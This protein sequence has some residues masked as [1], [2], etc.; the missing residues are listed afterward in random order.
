MMVVETGEHQWR[1]VMNKAFQH[2]PTMITRTHHRVMWTPSVDSYIQT[3][4]NI[5]STYS[6]II[7]IIIDGGICHRHI[8][9]IIITDKFPPWWELYW[10]S[11]NMIM[12]MVTRGSRIIII[13]MA[14]CTDDV[15]MMVL[16]MDCENVFTPVSHFWCSVFAICALS[17]APQNDTF[18][19]ATYNHHQTI[20]KKTRLMFLK[21]KPDAVV[22]CR[23]GSTGD[24]R[25]TKGAKVFLAARHDQSVSLHNQHCKVLLT[26]PHP[27]IPSHPSTYL[28]MAL[29]CYIHQQMADMW[30]Y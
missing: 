6:P 18:H 16:A 25:G 28:L 14:G 9:N 2:I 22:V 29:K 11:M 24:G 17:R 12:L 13:L 5:D 15:Q 10:E 23:A 8:P 27:G 7:I 19:I 30:P 4:T 20:V 26:S 3:Y 1:M 21:V